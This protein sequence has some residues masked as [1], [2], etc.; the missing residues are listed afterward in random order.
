MYS[1]IAWRLFF[2]NKDFFACRFGRIENGELSICEG[3]MKQYHSFVVFRQNNSYHY[4][5][6]QVCT[7][8]GRQTD[9]TTGVFLQERLG[10]VTSTVTVQVPYCDKHLDVIRK[11]K[12]IKSGL[13]LLSLI[14]TIGISYLCGLQPIEVAAI[15]GAV[16]WLIVI[17]PLFGYLLIKPLLRPFDKAQI[18][19]P[20]TNTLSFT[21]RMEMR[22]LVLGF[23]HPSI[24]QRFLLVNR[25]SSHIKQLQGTVMNTILSG[26]VGK[27]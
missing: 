18:F 3:A 22:G 5:L 19:E 7:H 1:I 13:Y 6:P 14:L 16:I 26:Q 12:R 25:N 10:W 23:A 17:R 8:C 15:C 11:F 2:N 24:A 21:A 20:D 9:K 4:N 27:S